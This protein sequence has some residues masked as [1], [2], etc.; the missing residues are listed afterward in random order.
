V[1]LP[2]QLRAVIT[3]V[4]IGQAHIQYYRVKPDCLGALRFFL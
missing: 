2:A 4:A 3:S 1:A